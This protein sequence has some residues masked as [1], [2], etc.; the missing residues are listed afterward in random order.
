MGTM[1][2]IERPII[3]RPVPAIPT[4]VALPRQGQSD[5]F[6]GWGVKF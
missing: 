5:I 6:N 4:R 2:I 1:S 3:D